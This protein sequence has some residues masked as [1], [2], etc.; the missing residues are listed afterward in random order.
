MQA[1]FEH[2]GHA[3]RLRQIVKTSDVAISE[4]LPL[5]GRVG[6]IFID[7]LHTRDCSASD[8]ALF[9]PLLRP[10]GLIAFHDCDIRHAGV[11]ATVSEIAAR[12]A[13]FTLRLLVDTIAVFERITD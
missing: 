6:F 1:L 11:F 2:S 8:F 3:P 10:G 13:G 9:A 12:E 7:G 5:A 4:L